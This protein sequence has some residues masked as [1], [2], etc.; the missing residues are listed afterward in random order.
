MRERSG[1]SADVYVSSHRA[2]LAKC[3]RVLIESCDIELR[4]ADQFCDLAQSHLGKH[5]LDRA[6]QLIESAEKAVAGAGRFTRNPEQR[7]QEIS[8]LAQ[9]I[10][11]VRQALN[12]LS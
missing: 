4:I 6:Q 1:E 9:R 11:R 3:K 8:E 12:E 7:R 5:H 2:I 10:A